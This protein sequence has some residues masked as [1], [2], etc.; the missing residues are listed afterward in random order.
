MA[1]MPRWRSIVVLLTLVASTGCASW[2][3]QHPAPMD[4][5]A[6]N[7]YPTGNFFQ[8]QAQDLA[9]ASLNDWNFRNPKVGW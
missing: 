7:L 4:T 9:Q 1:R 2:R 5:T 8:D 3:A 6:A